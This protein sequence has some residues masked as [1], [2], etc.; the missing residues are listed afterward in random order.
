MQRH[1]GRLRGARALDDNVG[2]DA[3]ACGLEPL[4]PVGLAGVKRRRGTKCEP[5]LASA[6]ARLDQAH[7][8]GARGARDLQG[9]KADRTAAEYRNCVT[10]MHVAFAHRPHGDFR[11]LHQRAF[12]IR[13]VR[14]QPRARK[15]RH[16][17][18]LGQSTIGHEA[19]RGPVLAQGILVPSAKE[20][21]TAEQHHFGRYSVVDLEA[22]DARTD[23]GHSTDEL[24]SEY[25]RR[26]TAGEIVWHVDRHN[27]WTCAKFLHVSPADPAP[28]NA[29]Q[30]LAL[31][32]FWLWDI[33]DAYIASPV[34]PRCFHALLPAVLMVAS[35]LSIG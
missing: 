9:E 32:R 34:P 11:W 19:Q 4:L 1:I 29:Q 25:Q 13:K 7:R 10:K 3:I 30:E 35:R 18:V 31:P 28:A 24:V 8:A 14:W 26:R 20:T 17:G 23:P 27:N 33:L 2:T 21:L 12:L 6:R 5:E 15:G 22:R 16:D